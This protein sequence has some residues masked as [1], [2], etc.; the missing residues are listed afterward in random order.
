MTEDF[1]TEQDRVVLL[2]EDDELVSRISKAMLMQLGFSVIEASDGL[3]AIEAFQQHRDII[4]LIICD[5]SMPHMN[6][7]ETF[8][9]LRSLAPDLLF[10][11]ASGYFNPEIMKKDSPRGPQ[12][13]LSKPFTLEDLGN[14]IAYALARREKKELS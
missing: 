8:T 11:L 12:A 10:I 7:W 2:I 14:T 1:K 13:F 4:S 5:L 3:K 6:G 9:A